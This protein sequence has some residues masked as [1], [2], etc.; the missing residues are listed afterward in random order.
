[1]Q[2]LSK[3]N[4]HFSGISLLYAALVLLILPL[5]W[6]VA[7][8]LAAFWHECCHSLAVLLCGGEVRNIRIG[9]DGVIMDCEPMSPVREV[10]CSMAGPLGSFLLIILAKWL[11]MTAIFAF[12]HG[13]YNLLPVYPLDGGRMLRTAAFAFLPWEL[14]DRVCMIVEC[15]IFIAV[16][17]LAVLAAVLLKLGMLPLLL[18]VFLLFRINKEKFLAKCCN[19]GYN[20]STIAKR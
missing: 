2:C 6:L 19:R 15:V 3:I 17:I 9:A 13:C 1:M 18:V 11:P 14:A 8:A 10:L 5:R 12:F 20:R 16:I 7:A 4:I